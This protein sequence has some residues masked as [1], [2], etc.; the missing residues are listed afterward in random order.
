MPHLIH[1]LSL[2]KALQTV[3]MGQVK[4]RGTGEQ[5]W[6]L[7][8]SSFA[9]PDLN[10]HVCGCR[11]PGPFLFPCLSWWPPGREPQ[12][13]LRSQFPSA[14]LVW[15]LSAPPYS[16]QVLTAYPWADLVTHGAPG[17]VRPPSGAG[18]PPGPPHF[19]LIPLFY[20]VGLETIPE[21]PQDP[22]SG[23]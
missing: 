1:S 7:K 4:A 15:P 6:S 20:C 13:C 11:Q 9:V 18:A 8:L 23:V 16:T 3:L 21:L 17:R 2:S 14:I 5:D 22:A 10:S 12:S 19:S